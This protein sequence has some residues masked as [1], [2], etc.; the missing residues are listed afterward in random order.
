M[1]GMWTGC[2]WDVDGMWMGM[3]IGMYACVYVFVCFG[4]SLVLV[5][6]CF[7]LNRIPVLD[8]LYKWLLKRNFKHQKL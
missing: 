6:I 2:G 3:R 7:Q 8:G 4:H 1:D 5:T